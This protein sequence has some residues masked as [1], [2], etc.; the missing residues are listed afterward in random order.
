LG[1][2]VPDGRWPYLADTGRGVR[3]ELLPRVADDFFVRVMVVVSERR[4]R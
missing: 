3:T 2:W 1:E 4:D